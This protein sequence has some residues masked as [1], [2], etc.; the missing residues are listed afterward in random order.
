MRDA[1]DK[2][3]HFENLNLDLGWVPGCYVDRACRSTK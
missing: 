2:V 1:K 3:N